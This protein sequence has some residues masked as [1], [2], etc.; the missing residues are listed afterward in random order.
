MEWMFGLDPGGDEFLNWVCDS[1]MMV[2][3]E[4]TLTEGELERLTALEQTGDELLQGEALAAEVTIMD[5]AVRLELAGGEMLGGDRDPEQRLHAKLEQS[6]LRLA[7]LTLQRD[8]MHAH[9]KKGSEKRARMDLENSTST[10]GVATRER[11]QQEGIALNQAL[12]ALASEMSALAEMHG[13]L[14]L[15]A[16][17]PPTTQQHHSHHHPTATPTAMHTTTRSFLSQDTAS[18]KQYIQAE[19]DF[20]RKLTEHVKTQFFDGFLALAAED[21]GTPCAWVQLDSPQSQSQT[22]A[23]YGSGLASGACGM[24][25]YHQNC[26]EL[27]RLQS[28]DSV[29]NKEPVTFCCCCCC[30]CCLFFSSSLVFFVFLVRL[31]SRLSVFS[32]L[33]VCVLYDNAITSQACVG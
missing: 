24:V 14:P 26:T 10:V 4:N 8:A 29:G 33:T 6:R 21:I 27:R 9:L 22:Q 12:Q 28:L 3:R 13:T 17:A 15:D 25:E 11:L 31:I 7:T 32:S 30:C 1:L 5:A 19:K 23:D 18:L 16:S 2:D 20:T